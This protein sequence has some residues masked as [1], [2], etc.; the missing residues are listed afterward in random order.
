MF[1][2]KVDLLQSVQLFESGIFR[3][4]LDNVVFEYVDV[5]RHHIKI[6]QFIYEKRASEAKSP[7]NVYAERVM[8]AMTAEKKKNQ[9]YVYEYDKQL[10]TKY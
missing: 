4:C 2:L 7:N 1:K 10:N 5:N 3:F 8:C 9:N 6:V